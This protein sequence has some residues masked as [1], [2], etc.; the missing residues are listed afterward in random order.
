MESQT[1][2]ERSRWDDPIGG[3]GCV[4]GTCKLRATS[5]YYVLLTC[6]ATDDDYVAM[7]RRLTRHDVSIGQAK[8][9][10]AHA[11]PLQRLRGRSKLNNFMEQTN[12]SC[13]SRHNDWGRAPEGEDIDNYAPLHYIYL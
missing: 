7:I 3:T 8:A 5:L 12:S 10:D 6:A 1:V 9:A 13:V 11:D 2:K 4:L